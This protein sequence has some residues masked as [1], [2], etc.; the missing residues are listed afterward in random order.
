[1][2]VVRPGT[3]ID[4]TADPRW[5]PFSVTARVTEPIGGIARHGGHLDGPLGWCAYLAAREAGIPVPPQGADWICDMQLPLATWT[6]P[7]A[8]HPRLHGADDAQVWGWACS[9]ALYQVQSMSA[10]RYRRMPDYNAMTRYAGVK[11]FHAGLGP[12]KAR[13]SAV[14][15]VWPDTVTWHALGDPDAT[16]NLLQ[17]LTALGRLVR[18][19]HGRI[20]QITVTEH[21]DR[22]AWRDRLWPAD[23]D[24]VRAPYWHPSRRL[25]ASRVA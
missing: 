7:G 5:R 18:H 9:R 13:D 11:K 3:V 25:H 8:G 15:A 17:H 20:D 1:M 6:M 14:E 19:G 4:T 22:D 2:T 24:A 21:T 12:T 16:R 23:G 10:I